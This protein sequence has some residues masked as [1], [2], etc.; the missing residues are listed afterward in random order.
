[1]HLHYMPLP[2]E[3]SG[4]STNRYY[5]IGYSPRLLIE[6]SFVSV[7]APSFAPFAKGGD[8]NSTTTVNERRG[9]K[10][11][12]LLRRKD[13]AP[14]SNTCSPEKDKTIDLGLLLFASKL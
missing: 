11:P 2:S 6:G 3:D 13:G 4:V 8:F 5:S 9:R 12:P 1:M 10:S 14:D 7:G